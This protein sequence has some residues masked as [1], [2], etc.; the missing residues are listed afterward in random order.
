MTE[1]PILPSVLLYSLP[2]IGGNLMQQL[3]NTFD[4]IIVG[5]LVG[6]TALAAV[7]AGGQILGLL[8]TAFLGAGAGAGILIAMYYGAQEPSTALSY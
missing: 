8:I 1:G 3:Y 7:G 2:L 6:D 5:N 4:S